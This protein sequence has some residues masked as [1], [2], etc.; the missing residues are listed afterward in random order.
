MISVFY[1]GKCGLCRREI[2]YYRRIAPDGKF[3]WIDITQN[4]RAI[5]DLGVNYSDGLRLLHA[6]DASGAL[7]IGVKA[8]SLIWRH[9]PYWSI[10]AAIVN[11]PVIQQAIDWAYQGF[12]RWRF[13]HHR[14]CQVAAL[15][16]DR[17]KT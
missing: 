17:T 9:L 7:H 11:L 4:P 1:D 10:M 15:A 16:D 2:N 13:N 14:H 3:L 5:E 8:F 12:A 6:Q